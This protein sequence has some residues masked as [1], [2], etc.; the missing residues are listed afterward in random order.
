MPRRLT[1]E[2]LQELLA[3]RRPACVS[4]FLPAHRSERPADAAAARAARLLDDAEAA[5]SAAGTPRGTA[6]AVLASVRELVDD[7]SSW[8]TSPAD[9]LAIFAAPGACF[10]VHLDAPPAP[11]VEVGTRFHL[12]PLFAAPPETAAER[13]RAL[14]RFREQGDRE[15]T[16]RDPERVVAA[17]AEGRVD[18]L[19]LVPGTR[20]W[21]TYDDLTHEVRLHA[22]REPGDDD[23]AD[24]A[25]A[26]TLTHGGTVVPTPPGSAPDG[27]PLAAILRS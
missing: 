2:V 1:P 10:A 27:A 26:C 6:D 14:V 5:L 13:E 25:V 7:L 23:L 8:W 18:T 11:S 19:F 17:A 15:R 21:G 3:V 12:A 24:L 16:A 20:R 9:G 4:I 22:V